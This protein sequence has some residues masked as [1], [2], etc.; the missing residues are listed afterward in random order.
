MIRVRW[1]GKRSARCAH[2][3]RHACLR[4]GLSHCPAAAA[5]ERERLRDVSQSP[6]PW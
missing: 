1:L 3:A 2:G 4:A 5:P 6:L